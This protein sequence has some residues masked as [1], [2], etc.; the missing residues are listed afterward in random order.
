MHNIHCSFWLEPLPANLFGGSIGRNRHLEDWTSS[1]DCIVRRISA[2]I[3]SQRRHTVHESIPER[4]YFGCIRL[5]CISNENLSE[6][7]HDGHRKLTINFESRLNLFNFPF[8][9]FAQGFYPKTHGITGNTLY[10][11][12][13]G[14]LGYGYE[15]YHYNESIWPIWVSAWPNWADIQKKYAIKKFNPFICF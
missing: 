5:Q 12:K 8:D 9:S 13:L 15:L 14:D 2:R 4:R 1:T 7:S 10:D 6:S 3:F 11:T